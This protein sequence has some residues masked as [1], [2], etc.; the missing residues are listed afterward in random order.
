MLHSRDGT[1]EGGEVK[2]MAASIAL[3]GGLRH[4]ATTRLPL[5]GGRRE[6]A[7][8]DEEPNQRN[9][10]RESATGEHS[11]AGHHTVL[12]QQSQ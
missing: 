2:K 8:G 3:T 6:S 11:S 10:I 1:L 7:S 12:L 9:E 4:R 5:G